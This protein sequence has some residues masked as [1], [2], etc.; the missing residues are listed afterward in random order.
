MNPLRPI[1]LLAAAVAFGVGVSLPLIRLEKLYFFTETPSLIAII[2]GLWNEGDTGLAAIVA[3]FSVLFPIVKMAT[4]F[5][6]VFS[7]AGHGA[8][9]AWAGWL[10]KWS[11]MDVL[12]VAIVVFAAKTSGFA[13]AVSQPGIWFYAMS[14]VLSALASTG[15]EPEA[16]PKR[17]KK[18]E[19]EEA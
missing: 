2:V 16:K 18:A 7:V 17:V 15:L 13:S 19:G 14:A 4:V 1:L 10:A 5:Q 11:M 9:P 6:A 3:V 12:L 8:Y